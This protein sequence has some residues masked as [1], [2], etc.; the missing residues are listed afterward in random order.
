M[1]DSQ[2]SGGSPDTLPAPGNHSPGPAPERDFFAEPDSLPR[3][4]D[5]R[6]SISKAMTAEIDAALS[7]I[8]EGKRGAV[9]AI[10]DPWTNNVN[11]HAAAK[12]GDKWKV[13]A[14]GGKRAGEGFTT[15]IGVVGAW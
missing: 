8:P 7:A 11:L 9:V 13:A 12:I 15:R 3:E 2:N 1:Q 4:L 5:M 10:W 14:T 6:P